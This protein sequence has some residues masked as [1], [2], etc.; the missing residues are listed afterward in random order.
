MPL[1]VSA[2]AR[3]FTVET[4]AVARLFADVRN[5]QFLTYFMRPDGGTVGGL[6]ETHHLTLNAAFRKVKQFETLG[7]LRVLGR[8]RRAGR[9]V[10]RYA[11]TA[12]SF[13]VPSNLMP[14]VETLTESFSSYQ[15]VMN[16]AFVRHAQTP[17]NP[18]GGLLIEAR[19][20]ELWMLPAT[21]SGERWTP[22][23][24][25][26]PAI[27]HASGALMLDYDQARALQ[28]ELVALF[29]RYR[30][31]RGSHAYLMHL[32]L[33]PLGTTHRLALPQAGYTERSEGA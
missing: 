3:P 32:F 14:L 25:G 6:A 18:V 24:P 8:E 13:F 26:T 12:S 27:H 4:P 28:R 19:G 2:S 7:L 10:K 20:G 33:T 29:D 5:V 31:A 15:A 17:P 22:H 30:A 16:E 1:A 23:V 9:P 21:P 11:C